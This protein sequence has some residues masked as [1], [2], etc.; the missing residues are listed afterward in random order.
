MLPPSIKIFIIAR[1][2]LGDLAVA[3]GLNKIGILSLDLRS[4]H[5]FRTFSFTYS[6]QDP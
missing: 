6:N 1:R 3:V 4:V 5:N 2:G